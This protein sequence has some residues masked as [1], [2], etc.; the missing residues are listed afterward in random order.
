MTSKKT[1]AR[2][3]ENTEAR[4]LDRDS[5]ATEVLRA[6][7]GKPSRGVIHTRAGRDLKLRQLPASKADKSV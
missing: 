5:P 2:P 7:H 6:S 3:R 1:D 4:V